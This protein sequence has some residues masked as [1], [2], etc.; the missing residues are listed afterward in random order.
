MDYCFGWI[1]VVTARFALGIGFSSRL[2]LQRT[3]F[4]SATK[5]W[6]SSVAPIVGALVVNSAVAASPTYSCWYPRPCNISFKTFFK[7]PRADSSHNNSADV[8]LTYVPRA[9]HGLP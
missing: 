9:H 2:P 7:S 5:G 6:T 8:G 4:Y 1:Y 3:K